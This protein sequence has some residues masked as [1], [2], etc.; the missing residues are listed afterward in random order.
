MNKAN[1]TGWKVVDAVDT[2]E[3]D[4]MTGE[5]MTETGDAVPCDH[6]GRG[7]MIHVAIARGAERA[8]VGL[9]CAKKMGSAVTGKPVVRLPCPIVDACIAE[10]LTLANA[11]NVH[12]AVYNQRVDAE[13]GNPLMSLRRMLNCRMAEEAIARTMA[14][15]GSARWYASVVR[16][17]GKAGV[18]C[19]TGSQ[20]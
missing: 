2:R 3:R 11:R 20:L 10:G 5:A 4:Q 18:V 9:A 6:C 15:E 16:A 19:L 8:I 14:N 7:I 12:V 13:R 17:L 1:G